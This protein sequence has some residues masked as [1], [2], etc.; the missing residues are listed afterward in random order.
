MI[1]DSKIIKVE[2][3]EKVFSISW[4]MELFCNYDCMY[5]PTSG[6]MTAHSLEK[7]FFTLNNIKDNWIKL[8]NKTKHKN[9]PY[10]ISITGGEPTANK[11]FL[12][13]IKWLRENYDVKTITVTSNGSAGLE[14]YRKL[15][16]YIENLSFSTHSE[17]FD[18]EKF[19]IKCREL[20]KIMADGKSFYVAVM[21][22]R[23]NQERIKLYKEF[24][25]KN[26]I[27]YSVN[28][29]YWKLAEF[30]RENHLSQGKANIEQIL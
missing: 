30:N 29:I 23:W 1:M 12:P 26:N 15:C 11:N 4:R 7:K 17:F 13:F 9:L 16:H 24:L 20:S 19:F 27:S 3:T 6:P 8:Y 14:Y 28:P 5:C 18:E 2:S 25:D 21:D 10:D 22:E